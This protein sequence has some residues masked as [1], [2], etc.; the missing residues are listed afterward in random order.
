MNEYAET[1]CQLWDEEEI[2]IQ[3]HS[4]LYHLEPIGIGTPMV[5]SLT[6]YITRLAEAHSVSPRVLLRDEILPIQPR[7]YLN[8]TGHIKQSCLTT[9]WS[10]SSV[11]NGNSSLTRDTVQTME[12]LTMCRDLRFLTLVSLSDIVSPRE[13]LR[14]TRSWCPTCYEQWREANSPIYDPLLWNINCIRV[15]LEHNQPLQLRCPYE[16]CARTLTSLTPRGQPGYCAWCNRWLGR[17]PDDTRSSDSLE[18]VHWMLQQ[19]FLPAIGELLATIPHLSEPMR[20]EYFVETI[21]QYADKTIKGIYTEATH[22][23]LVVQ[24]SLWNWAYRSH[25]PQL[26]NLLQVCAFLRIS[27]LSLFTGEA[28]VATKS[29]TDNPWQT[30]NLERTVKAA[31]KFDAKRVQQALEEFLQS[32]EYPPPS[33]REIARRLGY[34]RDH[35]A[36]LFPELCKAISRRYLEYLS[37]QRQQRIQK[38]CDEVR[39]TMYELHAQHRYPSSNQVSSSLGSHFNSNFRRPEVWAAW[40]EALQE[41]GWK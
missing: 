30:W 24:K 14:R 15:C 12:T 39:R 16:D 23:F 5:E 22:Q 27:L 28:I 41:L 10:R 40:K 6:S 21:S 38:L 11:L 26:E 29:Q 9:Y 31:R 34:H 3:P 20:R 13:L 17:L 37:E 25:L 18:E 4:R 1:L 2:E 32:S 35:L 8:P 7:F 19:H 36:K 33:M